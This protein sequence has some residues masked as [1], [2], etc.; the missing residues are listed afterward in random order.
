MQHRLGSPPLG[1]SHGLYRFALSLGIIFT[2]ALTSTK[3]QFT[4][5]V[6]IERKF[7]VRVLGS[8]CMLARLLPYPIYLVTSVFKS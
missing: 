7:G 4:V 6:G 2:E 1:P 3:F 5:F 8:I